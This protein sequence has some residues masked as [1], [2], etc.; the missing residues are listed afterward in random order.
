MTRPSKLSRQTI[1]GCFRSCAA[2]D[3]PLVRNISTSEATTLATSCVVEEES[4]S[5]RSSLR[6]K[7]QRGGTSI[8]ASLIDTFRCLVHCRTRLTT[9]LPYATLKLR[10][11]H[12]RT[13][14]ILVR[15]A[16]GAS[17]AAA[18]IHSFPIYFEMASS[19]PLK[20]PSFLGFQAFLVCFSFRG[21]D[22]TEPFSSATSP[23]A[24][25]ACVSGRDNRR[26]FT[27]C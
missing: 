15:K 16:T 22:R 11:K 5:S 8:H 27:R 1:D 7:G 10:K 18:Q 26:L 2:S 4:K 24:F 6:S 25:Q 20:V 21:V 17:T 23:K 12:E 19:R 3:V 14:M 13:A 9:T